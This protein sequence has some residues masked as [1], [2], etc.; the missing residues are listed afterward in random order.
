LGV[1]RVVIGIDPDS[2][3]HGVAVYVDMQLKELHNF[4]TVELVNYLSSYL[5]HKTNILVSIENVIINQFVYTRNERACKAAQS[6]I[7]ISVGR[8]MQSQYEVMQWLDHLMIKY[9]LHSP[10]KG[11]W[12]DKKEFFE[13]L[14]GWT[15]Q[16][17]DDT[18][19]AAF[20]GYLALGKNNDR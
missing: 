18:R 19:A 5:E 16:S 7:A 8:C 15:K 2:K 17:N 14:T 6:K 20:F 12:K 9:E 4:T 3:K 1:A 10:Q 13:K 11:N